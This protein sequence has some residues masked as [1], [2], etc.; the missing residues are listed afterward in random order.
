[1]REPW[2]HSRMLASRLAQLAHRVTPTEKLVIV[3]CIEETGNV[4]FGL[5]ARLAARI[6]EEGGPELRYLG[7]LHFLRETGHLMRG[8]EQREMEAITLAAGERVRCLDVAFRVFELFADWSCELHAFA[9]AALGGGLSPSMAVADGLGGKTIDQ[10]RRDE[11]EPAARAT[12]RRHQYQPFA[13][14]DRLDD[15]RGAVPGGHDLRLLHR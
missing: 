5:T 3:E 1:M 2:Q 11:L 14:V 8:L 9:R 6:E 12:A 4:L 15:S 10:R 7:Q 13:L